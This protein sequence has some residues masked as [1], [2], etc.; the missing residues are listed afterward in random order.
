[1]NGYYFHQM[2]ILNSTFHHNQELQDNLVF[3]LSG[4]NYGK[5]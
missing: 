5:Y 3:K 2:I 4:N 1:M